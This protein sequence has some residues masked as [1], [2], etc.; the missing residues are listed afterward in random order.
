[1]Q[2]GIVT[3][4]YP[5]N[6]KGGGETSAALLAEHLATSNRVDDVVVFSFDGNSTGRRNGVTVKRLCSVSPLLTEWQNCR[7]Y[8]NLRNEVKSF[9]ILHAYNMELH[10]T[11]GAI[12]MQQSILTVATLNSYHF[13]PKSVSNATPTSAERIYEVIGHPTTGRI[14]MALMSFINAFVAISPTVRNIYAEHGLN[15]NLI[16]VIP[17]MLDPSFSVPEIENNNGERLLY[18]GEL[19]ERKGVQYLLYALRILPPK[20]TLRIVGDGEN[21]DNLKKLASKLGVAGRVTFTGRVPYEEITKQ[22]ASADVFVHPGIW[23]EPFG[24]TILEAMQAKL[25]VVCTN[26]GGPADLVDDPELR[27][28]PGNPEDLAECIRTAAERGELLGKQ[29]RSYVQSEF[30]PETVTGR[31][32]DLYECLLA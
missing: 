27:C 30:R 10:P 21:A 12:S 26:I 28:Q 32:A 19:S 22:Y 31:I 5:P 15:S 3:P 18:V 16:E 25:P 24:R 6:V 11:V 8:L 7:A 2:V 17:N 1:M 14:M 4:R 20:F 9:D 23:P 13:L 29:N